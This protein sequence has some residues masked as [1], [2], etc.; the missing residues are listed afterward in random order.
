MPNDKQ[1]VPGGTE[2]EYAPLAFAVAVTVE[3]P[4]VVVAVTCAE[5]TGGFPLAADL[6]VPMIVPLAAAAGEAIE[7]VRAL[8]PKMTTTD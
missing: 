3:S 2:I 8:T 1:Y 4:S 7:K 5:G 6:T